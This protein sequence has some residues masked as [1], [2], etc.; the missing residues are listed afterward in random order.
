VKPVDQDKFGAPEG[1][2]WTACVASILEVSLDDLRDVEAAHAEQAQLYLEGVDW[3][4]TPILKVLHG[5]AVT[6]GWWP[7][8]TRLAGY[9]IACGPAPRGL[10]HA[11]VAL[12][13]EVVHDPHPSRAG[14]REIEL[15]TLIAPIAGVN[16]G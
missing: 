7:P 14:L 4:W 9:T 3:D 12:D 5:H 16:R 10:D 2:C 15:Y 11:C 6:L 1:N 8:E 13:G